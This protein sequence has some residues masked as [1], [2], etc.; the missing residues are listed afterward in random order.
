MCNFTE[1]LFDEIKSRFGEDERIKEKFRVMLKRAKNYTIGTVNIE[2]KARF[3]NV[4]FKELVEL[5]EQ[6]L[7]GLKGEI[8]KF[9]I[10]KG[11]NFDL[12]VK[13]AEILKGKFFEIYCYDCSS[14]TFLR[15]WLE[16]A[17]FLDKKWLS[18]DCDE[19][20]NTL[21]FKE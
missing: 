8:Q 15:L 12:G 4:L 19:I 18:V 10:R 6:K 2:P 20:K 7:Q 5:A 16:S 11:E 13:Q 3:V 21:W 9:G 1:A 17:L 14:V